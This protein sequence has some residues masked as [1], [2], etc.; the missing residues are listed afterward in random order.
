MYQILNN[1]ITFILIYNE[2]ISKE[3]KTKESKVTKQLQRQGMKEVRTSKRVLKS[4]QPKKQFCL[5]YVVQSWLS[6]RRRKL[7]YNI[8]KSSAY[9]LTISC[10][11]T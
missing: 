11:A 3:N 5:A 7:F 6:R 1:F 10:K 8:T 2:L 4:D 9:I